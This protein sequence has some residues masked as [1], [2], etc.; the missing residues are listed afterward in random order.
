MSNE[1]QQTHVREYW[2]DN[3]QHIEE[4]LENTEDN[5]NVYLPLYNSHDDQDEDPYVIQTTAA[6]LLTCFRY[7]MSTVL[8]ANTGYIYE[9]KKIDFKKMYIGEKDDSSIPDEM[10]ILNGLN[11]DQE[12]IIHYNY[13][14]RSF[15]MKCITVGVMREMLHQA[16]DNSYMYDNERVIR[17]EGGDALN[18]D[19]VDDHY[20]IE[21]VTGILKWE[22]EKNVKDLETIK[23][24]EK[25]G[26]DTSI[27]FYP[28]SD[29]TNIPRYITELRITPA[30]FIRTGK[31]IEQH[32]E[33][34]KVDSKEIENQRALIQSY[35]HDLM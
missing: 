19:H 25:I 14:N 30:E 34:T 24:L 27:F 32:I 20:T 1:I 6:K 8:Q 35:E 2:Y 18:L 9:V 17:F 21:I 33:N 13:K 29:D 31:I 16:I 5:R 23:Q 15:N 4:S 10:S 22:H 3:K 28:T 26:I 12:I 7:N 11:A